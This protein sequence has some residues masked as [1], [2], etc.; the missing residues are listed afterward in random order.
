METPAS[1]RRHVSSAMAVIE[2]QSLPCASELPSAFPWLFAQLIPPPIRFG[3][4]V[5]Y[6]DA[7][8]KEGLVTTGWLARS[9]LCLLS[10]RSPMHARELLK[11]AVQFVA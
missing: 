6:I 9:A 5:H 1:P 3:Y 7:R 8:I 2:T 4:A 11:I 10:L